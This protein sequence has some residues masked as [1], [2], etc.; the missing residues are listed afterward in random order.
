MSDDDELVRLALE[1]QKRAF[2]PYSNFPVGA[3]LRTAR[4][5]A[6]HGTFP[7]ADTAATFSEIN[8]LFRDD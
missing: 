6:D 8:Q 2:C 1:A 7:I 4:E 5:I 3:A